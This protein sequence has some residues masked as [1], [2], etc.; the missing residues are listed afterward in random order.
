MDGD[1]TSGVSGALRLDLLH[2]FVV[3]A[4]ERQFTRAARRL[5]ISQSGLS[6]RISLLE[7]IVGTPLL[8]RTTRSVEVTQAGAALVPHAEAI[9]RAARAA[10]AATRPTHRPPVVGRRPAAPTG[11]A[12]GRVAVRT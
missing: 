6:R 9:L 4:Q 2:A 8:T 3:L 1:R 12:S 7:A 5:Y 11:P 10:M